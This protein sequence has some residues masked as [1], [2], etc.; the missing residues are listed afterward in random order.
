MDEQKQLLQSLLQWMDETR[1]QIRSDYQ[2]LRP[3]SAR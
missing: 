1:D 3:E 2:R